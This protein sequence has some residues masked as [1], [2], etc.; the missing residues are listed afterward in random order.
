M[1]YKK[2]I[3]SD[4]YNDCMDIV[5][6]VETDCMKIATTDETKAFF[7]KMIGDYYRYVA[8]CA[9]PEKLE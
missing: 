7:F 3:E 9:A 2:K 5:K 1:E 4:L 8:E 6:T